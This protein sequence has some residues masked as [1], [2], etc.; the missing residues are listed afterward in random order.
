V[1]KTK[2]KCCSSTSSWT[3]GKLEGKLICYEERSHKNPNVI[4]LLLRKYASH[5]VV[6]TFTH[7]CTRLFFKICMVCCYIIEGDD[8]NDVNMKPVL[9]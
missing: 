7:S 8:F 1:V 5:K 2:R 9:S 4:K 6:H 3:E